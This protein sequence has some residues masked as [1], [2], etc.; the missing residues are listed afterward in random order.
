MG[1]AILTMLG[2]VG[3]PGA[4]GLVVTMGLGLFVCFLGCRYFRFSVGVAGFVLGAELAGQLALAQG[5]SRVVTLIVGV[6]GGS[7]LAALFV[8]FT[9]LGVFGLGAAM[10]ATVVSLGTRG[11]AQGGTWPLPLVL[12]G[13]IGG[14][15][16]LELRQPVVVVTTSLYG[17]LMAMASLFALLRGKDVGAAVRMM[18]SQQGAGDVALFLLC[19]TVLVTGG[20]VVQGRFGSHPQLTG[21]GKK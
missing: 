1:N 3:D 16:A 10:A 6:L 14:F 19:V 17:G 21:G 8:A 11:A 18:V 9:F 2:K 13:L 15:G 12:A 7:A 20:I 5:W 4:A